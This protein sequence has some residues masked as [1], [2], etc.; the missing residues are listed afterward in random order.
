MGSC[1]LLSRLQWRKQGVFYCCTNEAMENLSQ[2]F[3]ITEAWQPNSFL[4]KS[5]MLALGH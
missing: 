4:S 3:S 5:L 2:A 1:W